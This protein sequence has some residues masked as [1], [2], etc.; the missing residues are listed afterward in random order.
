MIHLEFTED[1]HAQLI[2]TV[3]MRLKYWRHRYEKAQ[4]QRD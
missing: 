2:R 3:K 4:E 1:E